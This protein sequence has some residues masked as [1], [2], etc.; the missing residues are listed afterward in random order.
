MRHL[1]PDGLGKRD[2]FGEARV[3]LARCAV[4]LVGVRWQNGQ[5]DQGAA[6]G[7]RCR[8]VRFVDLGAAGNGGGGT[9]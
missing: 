8:A 6:R 5:D 7:G 2:C 1:Q 4:P 9:G 3:G